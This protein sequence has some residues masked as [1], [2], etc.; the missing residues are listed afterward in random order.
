MIID[1][2]TRTEDE[3]AVVSRK[4]SHG[5]S[6]SLASR[7]V[8]EPRACLAESQAPPAKNNNVISVSISPAS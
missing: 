3:L 6:V 1:R 7:I 5:G 8:F 4:A 2:S